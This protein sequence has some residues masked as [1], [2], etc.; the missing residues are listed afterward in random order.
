MV[1]NLL[2]VY[3]TRLCLL[4]SS[5]A[6]RFIIVDPFIVPESCYSNHIHYNEKDEYDNVDNRDFSPAF[7][8]AGQYTGFARITLVTKLVLIISPSKTVWVTSYKPTTRAPDCLVDV[9]VATRCRRF[10]ASRLHQGFHKSDF[11]Q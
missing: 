8:Q 5:L 4:H 1:D 2:E 3:P 10:A 7:L 9:R 6:I 11:I